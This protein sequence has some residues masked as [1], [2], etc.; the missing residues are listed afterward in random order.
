MMVASR[1][2]ATE[3]RLQRN[4]GSCS[5]DSHVDVGRLFVVDLVQTSI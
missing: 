2:S 5:L 4:V 3:F 1:S